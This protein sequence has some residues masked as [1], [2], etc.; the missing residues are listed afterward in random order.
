MFSQ[1]SEENKQAT[2]K[3]FSKSCSYLLQ[4]ENSCSQNEYLLKVFLSLAF[5]FN[6]NFLALNL[7]VNISPWTDMAF[8]YYPLSY[9]LRLLNI[10][11]LIDTASLLIKLITL[12]IF[13]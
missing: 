1:C 11:I 10:A 4:A 7:S 6:F 13:G 5:N 8:L 12:I 9:Q 2:N 3:N